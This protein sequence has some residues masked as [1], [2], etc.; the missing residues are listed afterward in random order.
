[1]H[2]IGHQ[3]AATDVTSMLRETERS[4]YPSYDMR[5]WCN[6]A[7]YGFDLY[8]CSIAFMMLFGPSESYSH[9]TCTWHTLIL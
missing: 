1:M 8:F 7:I 6:E 2:S 4:E 5:H 3:C 9:D